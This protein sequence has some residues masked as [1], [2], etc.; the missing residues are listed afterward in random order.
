MN[1]RD[2]EYWRIT[3][4]AWVA[5]GCLVIIGAK[6]LQIATTPELLLT[7]EQED[8]NKLTMIC[9]AAIIFHMGFFFKKRIDEIRDY[10]VKE[11]TP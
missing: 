10:H 8:L 6:V 3:I 7:V 2:I 5:L 11:E 4:L 1:I 9:V